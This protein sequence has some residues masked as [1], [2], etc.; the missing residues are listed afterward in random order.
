VIEV[1]EKKYGPHPYYQVVLD[2]GTGWVFVKWFHGSFLRNSVRRDVQIAV[3]GKVSVFKEYRQFI[4]P[5][6]QVLY[7]ATRGD[8]SQ[9]ELLPVYPASGKLTSSTIATSSSSPAA[10]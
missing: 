6:V 7:D 10:G 5:R 1:T 3:S 8:L 2:D 4:N 9:D